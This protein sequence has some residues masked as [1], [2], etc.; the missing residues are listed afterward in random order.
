MYLVILC[1][2]NDINGWFDVAVGFFKSCFFFARRYL[3]YSGLG[4]GCEMWEALQHMAD[5]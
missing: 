3:H 4:M 1:W 2:I 5:R